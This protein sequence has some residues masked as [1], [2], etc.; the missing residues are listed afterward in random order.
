MAGHA[1]SRPVFVDVTS[2]ETIE[3]LKAA[4]GHGFDIAMANK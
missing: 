1:V 2:D 3:L 4:I